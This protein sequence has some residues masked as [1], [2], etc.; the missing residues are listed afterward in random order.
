MT[1]KQAH[2]I[3]LLVADKEQEGFLSHA[4]IDAF[5]H[6]AQM[7]YFAEL[8]GNIRQYQRTVPPVHDG[9]TERVLAELNPFRQ[10]VPFMNVGF[11]LTTGRY[12]TLPDGILVLPDDLEYN[13]A[14]SALV[15]EGLTSVERP[16]HVVTAEEWPRRASSALIPVTA[17]DA[18]ARHDGAGGTVNG[19]DIGA[20]RKMRLLPAS[21]SGWLTY[22]RT[23]K[24]PNFVYTVAGRVV[25]HDP[26][27][28]QDLEWNETGVMNVIRKALIDIGVK[29]EDLTLLNTETMHDA[30]SA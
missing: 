26:N 30:T 27:A 25:T 5:L 19:I 11:N 18:I 6:V 7:S 14:L 8:V 9:A 1:I 29:N 22:L 10:S 4:D 23:P 12:G 21:L 28:S 20:R 15:M 24:R 17:S 13:E 3:I 16:I 2:D